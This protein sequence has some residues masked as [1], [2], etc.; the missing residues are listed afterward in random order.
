MIKLINKVDNLK[1]CF[2]NNVFSMEKWKIYISDIVS[3]E[4]NMFID[5]M[6]EVL[7]TNQYTFDH[8]F[9]PILN[10]ALQNELKIN[11]L[12]ETFKEVTNDLDSK[13]HNSFGKYVDATIILYLGLCN[14]AGWVVSLNEEP[15]IFL[16]IEKILELEWTSKADLEGLIYHEL[17]H[18]Y[19]MQ[20]GTL[21]RQFTRNYDTFLWQLFKEGVAMYFEQTLC[22]DFN[23]YNRSSAWFKWCESHLNAIKKDFNN[24]L[25]SM[26][27]SNQRYF[28]DWVSYYGYGDVG[29]Y[30]GAKFVQ[31][32][33]GYHKF[34]DII[35][36]DIKEVKKQYQ[37]FLKR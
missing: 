35:T 17:G 11:Q 27:Y 34:D 29:Y 8:D 37:K 7:N 15:I 19:H 2:P 23:F 16:G 25:E 12:V 21:N 30:L 13:V 22:N 3:G 32:V 6:N 4:D 5:D 18:L 26:T 31:Y 24:D 36:W 28:G 1:R 33:M 20:Y 10:K 9:L 14:G